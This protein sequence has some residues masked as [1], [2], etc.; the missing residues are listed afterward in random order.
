MRPV[1]RCIRLSMTGKNRKMTGKNRKW[2]ITVPAAV[3][4]LALY[5][6]IFGFSAQDGEQ[7]GSLS[8]MIS[9]KCVEL[10]NSL[11]GG[12]WS[13]AF[14]EGLAAYFEHPIRKLAHFSEYACM[15]ILVYVL[16]AQWMDRGRRLYLLTVEWVFLSAAADEFHQLFVPGR[17]GSF[18]DVLLDTCGGSFGM[19]LCMLAAY[20]H[21]RSVRKRKAAGKPE[22]VPGDT[23]PAGTVREG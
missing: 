13:K 19:A 5:M 17:Y 8:Q 20:L 22:A 9:E 15:G 12:K 2:K 18:A 23:E 14:M 16:W 3:L 11:S 4:L 1:L 7:S 10:F 6:V 21:R